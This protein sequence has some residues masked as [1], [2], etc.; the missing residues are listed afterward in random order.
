MKKTILK[1]F[2]AV[3]L[4]TA[5]TTAYDVISGS[6]SANATEKLTSYPDGTGGVWNKDVVNYLIANG[7][8]NISIYNIDQ[9][10]DRYCNTNLVGYYTVVYVSNRQIIGFENFPIG[11][12]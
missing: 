8:S 1:A 12:P 5:A 10:G 11:N 6:T 4:I 2:L 9:Y 3:L 7:F